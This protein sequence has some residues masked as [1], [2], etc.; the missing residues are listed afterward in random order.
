[1]HQIKRTHPC[2]SRYTFSWFMS[3]TCRSLYSEPERRSMINFE[4]FTSHQ[5]NRYWSRWSKQDMCESFFWSAATARC[6]Q[7]HQSVLFLVFDL[8]YFSLC[9]CRSVYFIVSVSR[10]IW[11]I[12]L[13]LDH[14]CDVYIP[15]HLDGDDSWCPS[16]YNVPAIKC[17]LLMQILFHL[18]PRPV[19]VKNQNISTYSSSSS[20]WSYSSSISLGVEPS[21]TELS[22]RRPRP[23]P[24]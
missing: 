22:L 11:F 13:L 24:L 23:T 5:E 17:P 16:T 7:I 8:Y 20:W 6:V 3:C 10:S 18:L 4:F 15:C 19:H 12:I 14:D 1:M 21:R 9:R 2:K